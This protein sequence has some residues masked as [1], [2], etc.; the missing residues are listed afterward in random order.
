MGLKQSMNQ[1]Q[2]D[3]AIPSHITIGRTRDNAEKWDR[4][5]PL[6]NKEHLM[7]ESPKIIIFF[8]VLIL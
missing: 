3:S 8:Y 2:A 1:T 6:Y 7:T 5:L 4:E